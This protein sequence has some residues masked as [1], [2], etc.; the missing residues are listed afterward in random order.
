MHA[1]S[2]NSA[3]LVLPAAYRSGPFAL[4]RKAWVIFGVLLGV[5]IV[6]VAIGAVLYPR[7]VQ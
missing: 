2:A 1:D 6:L 5:T 3:S 7:I 4:V